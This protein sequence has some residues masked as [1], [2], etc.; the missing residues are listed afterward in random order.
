MKPK[1]RHTRSQQASLTH[2]TLNPGHVGSAPRTKIP[3]HVID[4]LKPIG[5]ADEG[6]TPVKDWYVDIFRRF[7]PDGQV[8]GTAAFQIAP[9]NKPMSKVPMVI[10]FVC[11]SEE[12]S[13]DAWA[14]ARHSHGNV[15]RFPLAWGL[16][17]RPQAPWLAVSV[18]PLLPFLTDPEGAGMLGSLEQALAWMLIEQ[19]ATHRPH[20][21]L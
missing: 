15:L 9:G 2:V 10:C 20:G 7:G 19:E 8:P 3:D 11:W 4:L 6:P 5:D 14:E 18:S 16:R 13:E 1:N 17:R 12:A 21:V